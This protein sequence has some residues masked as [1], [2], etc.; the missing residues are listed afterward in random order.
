[1]QY[2]EGGKLLKWIVQFHFMWAVICGDTV[3]HMHTHTMDGKLTNLP[4]SHDIFLGN[5]QYNVVFT[6]NSNCEMQQ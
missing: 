3:T 1:M 2:E 6:I 5:N 4:I